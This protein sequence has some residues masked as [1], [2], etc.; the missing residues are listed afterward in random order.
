LSAAR[1][2]RLREVAMIAAIAH[3]EPDKLAEALPAAQ[4]AHSTEKWW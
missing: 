1:I 3:N 4:P 2:E